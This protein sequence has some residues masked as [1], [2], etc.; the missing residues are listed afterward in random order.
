[1]S[2][3]VW[4]PLT[5]DLRNQGLNNVTATNN[6]STY[7]STGGKL[8]GCYNFTTASW[9]RITFPYSLANKSKFSV[10]LWIKIPGTTIT[11]FHFGFCHSGDYWQF[12]TYNN[13]VGIRDNA[14]GSTGTRKDY[15][16]GSFVANQWT[17][18]AFTYNAGTLKIYKDGVLF[19]TNSTGGTVM[20]DYTIAGSG[21]GEPITNN[22]GYYF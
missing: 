5:K 10:C 14:S 3:Q 2:L 12:I 11:G 21:L 17:H 19:S 1:M 9:Q 4:L 6:G 15:S 18:L 22:S 20:N 16:L 13:T 8:G 7:S